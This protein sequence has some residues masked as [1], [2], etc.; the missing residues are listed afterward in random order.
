[1]T[2]EQEIAQAHESIEFLQA[3]LVTESLYR[4]RDY[5]KPVKK[6]L[7]FAIRE[8]SKCIPSK[9]IRERWSPNR[10]PCCGANLGGECDDGY[11]QNPYYEI[12]PECRQV[13]NYEEA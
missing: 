12:C 2:K 11:Y 4:Y 7:E 3:I 10:C 9:P 6:E 5:W 1:M 13:L 8:V